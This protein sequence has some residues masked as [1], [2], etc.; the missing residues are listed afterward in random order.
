MILTPSP[1]PGAY[2]PGMN[3]VQQVRVRELPREQVAASCEL[4]I[5]AMLDV[6]LMAK[7]RY[8]SC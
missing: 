1:G 5:D 8:Q 4:W 2:N 3:A 6:L 7:L